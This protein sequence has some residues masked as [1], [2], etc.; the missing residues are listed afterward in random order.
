MTHWFSFVYMGGVILYVDGDNI[1][2]SYFPSCWFVWIVIKWE[3]KTTTP[4]QN[5]IWKS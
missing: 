4:I 5:W 3:T 2:I 1:A